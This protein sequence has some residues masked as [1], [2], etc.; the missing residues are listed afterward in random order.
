LRDE[1]SNETWREALT[2]LENPRL[3]VAA[4]EVA[5]RREG[6]AQGGWL[7]AAN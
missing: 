7:T 4:H 2:Q 6:R 5:L 3:R 1:P